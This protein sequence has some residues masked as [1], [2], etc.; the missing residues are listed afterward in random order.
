MS[1]ATTYTGLTHINILNKSIKKLY[2]SKII[3]DFGKI[4]AYY[5]IG[6]Q[7]GRNVQ[8]RMKMKNT[9][10]RKTDRRWFE[11]YIGCDFGEKYGIFEG[12]AIDEENG[13]IQYCFSDGYICYYEE[14]RKIMGCMIDACTYGKIN[15]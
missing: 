1:R 3:V 2:K 12:T 8:R 15:N 9:K 11:K 13:K 4:W 10:E 7:D 5:I 6:K 14:A